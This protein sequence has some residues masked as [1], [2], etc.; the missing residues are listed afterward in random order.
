M[1]DVLEELCDTCI[2][3]K[4]YTKN[5]TY[6]KLFLFLIIEYSQHISYYKTKLI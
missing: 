6:M 3:F 4:L 2:M 1:I 5:I